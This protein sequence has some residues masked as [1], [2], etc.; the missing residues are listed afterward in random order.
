[1]TRDLR[2]PTRV[3][4]FVVFE[5]EEKARAR[6]IDPRRKEGLE[7]VRAT[8]AEIFEGAPEFSDLDVVDDWVL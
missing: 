5:S 1:M 7:A 6:E 2:D 3:V 8:I 4:T